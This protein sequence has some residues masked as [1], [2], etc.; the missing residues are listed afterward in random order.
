MRLYNIKDFHAK[1]VLKTTLHYLNS[2]DI[3]VFFIDSLNNHHNKLNNN[4]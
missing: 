2:I 4:C 3:I 1:G